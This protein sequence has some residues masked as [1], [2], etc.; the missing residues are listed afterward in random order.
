[1]SCASSSSVLRV[2][3]ILVRLSGIQALHNFR[4]CSVLFAGGCIT[5]MN[6]KSDFKKAQRHLH[7]DFMDMFHSLELIFKK[8]ELK[9]RTATKRK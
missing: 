3:V 5:E 6:F 7:M 8:E 9:Y 1:M 2:E 4:S